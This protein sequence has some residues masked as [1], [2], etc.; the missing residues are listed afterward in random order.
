M[1]PLALG[2]FE[3]SGDNLGQ[4]LHQCFALIKATIRQTYDLVGDL[5]AALLNRL[6]DV[7][8]QLAQRV[9]SQVKNEATAVKKLSICL[10]LFRKHNH[11]LTFGL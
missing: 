7:P 10:D 3:R 5:A 1:L 9:V 4:R 6:Q 2:L 11:G 8:S